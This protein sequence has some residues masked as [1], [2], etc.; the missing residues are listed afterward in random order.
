MRVVMKRDLIKECRF[1]LA[2]MNSME[3]LHKN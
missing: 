1:M 3:A 2:I